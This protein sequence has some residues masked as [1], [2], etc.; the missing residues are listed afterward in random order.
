M[1]TI[2][3][4]VSAGVAKALSESNFALASAP[5]TCSRRRGVSRPTER[6]NAA[7]RHRANEAEVSNYDF[8]VV[9]PTEKLFAE[10]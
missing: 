10:G 5:G 3:T 9:V 8:L 7:Q 4:R 2:L 6:L 1:L